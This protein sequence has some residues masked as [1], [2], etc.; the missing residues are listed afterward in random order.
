M[1][2]IMLTHSGLAWKVKNLIFAILQQKLIALTNIQI[3][4]TG[5][6]SS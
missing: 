6:I 2:E 4:A 1:D 5:L 3:H